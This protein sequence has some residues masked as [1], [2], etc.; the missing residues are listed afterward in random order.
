MHGLSHKLLS[1]LLTVLIAVA[2][3]SSALAAALSSEQ[4]GAEMSMHQMHLP[5]DGSVAS[6]DAGEA[7]C[8]HCNTDCCTQ[9]SCT[10]ASCGTCA[11]P[12]AVSYVSTIFLPGG[13]SAAP[14]AL[15]E[16]ARVS[17]SPFRPPRA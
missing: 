12:I 16:L 10:S 7:A 3:M 5:S 17:G 6:D 8:D 1:I 2:P 4:D 13:N 14:E 15:A 11:T 9:G